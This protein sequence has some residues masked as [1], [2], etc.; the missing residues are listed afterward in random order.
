MPEPRVSVLVVAK[1]EAHN[2]PGCLASASS[3]ACTAGCNVLTRPSR[4][5]GKPV[6]SSTFVTGRPAAAIA[7]A[8][9]PVE[10]IS[11]PAWCSSRARS[12]NPVLSWT[13][14]SARLIGTSVIG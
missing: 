3:P 6:M 13:L 9:L 7:A 8:V 11:T 2:L 5:S 14:I 12:A 1:N 4:H 10:T